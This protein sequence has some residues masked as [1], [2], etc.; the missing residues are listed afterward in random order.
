MQLRLDAAEL[1]AK[2]YFEP[3]KDALP[4]SDWR[5]PR[6]DDL[7]SIWEGCIGLDIETRDPLLKEMGPGC[8]RDPSTNYIVG[9]SLSF[10]GG[11]SFYLPVAHRGGDNCDWDVAGYL[12][13]H[14]R[15]F[16]GE[17]VGANNVYDM[18]WLAT[19]LGDDAILDC[20]HIDVLATDVLLDEN[21]LSY[22]LDAVAK[23]HG[24]AGKDEGLLKQVAAAYR[25]NLKTD[26]WRFP[27]RY[28][29]SYAIAD[30]ALPLEVL[31]RQEV[32]IRN[33]SV[34]KIWELE[35]QVTPL[36]AKMRRRGVRVDL[37]RIAQIEDL[38]ISKENDF[39]KEAHAISGVSLA[40]EDIWRSDALALSLVAAGYQI[41]TTAKGKN[42]VDK[43]FLA[44]CGRLG[45]VLSKAREWNKLRTTFAK[46]VKDHAIRH[47]ENDWRVHCSFHQLR[48]DSDEDGKGRGVRHGRFSSTDFNLQQMPAR[49]D[50][51][52]ELWRS[53]FIADIGKQWGC[54]D[55]SQQEPRIAVH[56]AE[57]LGLRGAKEFADEYRSNPKTDVHQKLADLT[58]FPRKLTKNYVNGLLYGMGNAK[59]CH[60]IGKPTEFRQ[61]RGEMREVAGPE[62][63]AVIEQFEA[64][65]PWLRALTREASD[66]AQKQGHVWTILRRKCRFEIGPDGRRMWTHKAFNRVG[67]GSAADAMKATLVAADR[68][69]IPFQ[70]TVHDEVDFSFDDPAMVARMKELMLTT[71]TFSVPMMVDVEI[72]PSWG[73]LKKVEAK[74]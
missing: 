73:E 28:V 4:K 51:F 61:I 56:Y 62:G 60:S 14:L 5:P 27:A 41:P 72:G 67:Q 9:I 68:E 40:P 13:D 19:Y 43:G 64:F 10:E 1:W 45:A 38:S 7:P 31:K 18:D 70:M 15:G 29:A 65:A 46:Q 30:A 12:R 69:G 50:D 16:R 24:L 26:L 58:G 66:R 55:W 36:C 42:S 59:L 21:Q 8:R 23:R 57:R 17:I 11:K 44:K 54:L 53:V 20:Q 39:L 63:Q 48:G 22:S 25:A 47:G 3:S 34:E 35:R 2:S 32:Q 37:D 74:P 71:V 49:N 33:E 6:A 52:G